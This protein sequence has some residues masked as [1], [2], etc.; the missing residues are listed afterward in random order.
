M[1]QEADII[2]VVRTHFNEQDI[3]EDVAAH[4]LM[5]IYGALEWSVRG[6][7]DLND[8]HWQRKDLI[9]AKRLLWG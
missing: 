4:L 1:S 5:D 2:D 9:A 6:D 8:D 3:T 7:E